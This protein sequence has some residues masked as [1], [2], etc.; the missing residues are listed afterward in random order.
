[1]LD[2]DFVAITTDGWTSRQNDSYVSLT[3]VYI[4]SGWGLH[5]LSLDCSKHTGTTTGEDL[6]KGIVTMIERHDLT[7]RVVA[8][9]TDCEP[10]MIKAG[11]LLEVGGGLLSHVGCSNHRLESTTS[12]V[13]N[14]KSLGA[15]SL[16]RGLVGRYKRSSQMAARLAAVCGILLVTSLCV[17]QDVETRWGS[18]WAMVRRLLYL[19][20]AIELRES[21]DKINPLLSDT[22]W[23]VLRLIDPILEP[24]MLAQKKLEGAQCVTGSLAIPTIGELRMTI[25]NT[26]RL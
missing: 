8:C 18:T 1:M 21:M 14:G 24:F 6:A 4:D 26:W 13:F 2:G 20:G 25:A 5:T 19:K 16:A 3:V 15:L 7:G 22:D 17:M 9:V 10:S 11:R 23:E 12:S